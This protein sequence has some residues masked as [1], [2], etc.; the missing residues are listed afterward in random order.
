M[1]PLDQ[2][3]VS[4]KDASWNE[5]F[6]AGLLVLGILA[7]GIAPFWLNELVMPGADAFMKSINRIVFK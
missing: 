4:I 5:K 3:Y 7:I 1:G 2:Q 6:A